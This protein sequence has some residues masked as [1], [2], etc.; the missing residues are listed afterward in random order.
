MQFHLTAVKEEGDLP[1]SP[2]WHY[3]PSLRSSLSWLHS[4]PLHTMPT[5]PA[6]TYQHHYT[7]PIG[8]APFVNP[9]LGMS[10][11]SDSSWYDSQPASPTSAS[12]SSLSSGSSSG[13]P[14]ST[15]NSSL[16]PSPREA[17]LA[18]SKGLHHHTAKMWELQRRQIERERLDQQIGSP[19]QSRSPRNSQPSAVPREPPQ[20]Q[21]ASSQHSRS[22]TLD[23]LH[24]IGR[25]RSRKD[26]DQTKNGSHRGHRSTKSVT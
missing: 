24:L 21:K 25:S 7:V 16:P 2:R 12:S 5:P 10:T 26:H 14:T 11:Y 13:S 3:R 23:I 19:T 15:L 17:A 1:R 8:G 20:Q 9:S 6:A 22:S 4:A 18:Y